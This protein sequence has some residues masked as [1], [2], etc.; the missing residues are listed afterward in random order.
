MVANQIVYSSL[1]Q[2]SVLKFLLFEKGKLCE[3]YRR[4]FDLYG[5]ACFSQ[6]KYLLM[7]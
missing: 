4:I 5:E 1:E 6:K 7:G 2:R 3:I